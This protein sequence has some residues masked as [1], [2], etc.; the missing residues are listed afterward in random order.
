MV[1]WLFMLLPVAAAS[2]WYAARRTIAPGDRGPARP[3]RDPAYFQGLNFLLSDQ[4]DKAVDI[5]IKVLEVDSDTIE[6]HLSLGNLFRRRGESERAIRVHQ[7]LVAHSALTTEQR[8]R[9]LLELG[10]DYMRAGVLDRAESLF[11]ELMEM[12]LHTE[13]SLRH[14][15]TIY[16]Q[17]KD[18][19]E[20]IAATRRLE[21]ESSKP[22]QPVIAQYY[23]EKAEAALEHGDSSEARTLAKRA[24][25]SDDCCVRATMLL[26]DLAARQG[27]MKLAVSEYQRVERQ[28]ADYLSEVVAPICDCYRQLGETEA[29]VDYLGRLCDGVGSVAAML[30]LAGILHERQGAEQASA[31]VTERLRAAPNLQGLDRLISLNLPTV[32]GCAQETL[33]LL[34]GLVQRLLE[35]RAGYR[36]ERCGFAATTLHWQ[37]PSCRSWSSVKPLQGLDGELH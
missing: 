25:D 9:A 24:R 34:Q 14:L 4:P 21:A 26:G 13:S 7:N 17:T 27:D 1:E 29:L 35:K 3:G 31:F 15:T 20:A 23:C 19:D 32:S 2:G 36:C 12:G 30:A 22:M 37:C 16:Q 28:D 6:T 11:Q 8:A 18:W 10:K 33:L 5:F